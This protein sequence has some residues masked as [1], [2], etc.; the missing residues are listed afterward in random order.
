MS[1]KTRQKLMATFLSD[2]TF[3]AKVRESPELIAGIAD[4]PLE[5]VLRLI[6]L[7]PRRLQ[8][9]RASQQVKARR[10]LA[11]TERQ[12]KTPASRKA[13]GRSTEP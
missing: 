9:C 3:E 13:S 2:P 8:V 11:R 5:E 1:L 4:V 6:G 7:E 12:R 10:R